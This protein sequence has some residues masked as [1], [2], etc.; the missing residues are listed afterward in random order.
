MKPVADLFSIVFSIENDFVTWKEKMWPAVLEHYGI[1]LESL[2]YVHCFL[3]HPSCLSR[4]NWK[5]ISQ[6]YNFELILLGYHKA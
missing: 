4:S 2:T 1:D 6:F 3:S 5:Y